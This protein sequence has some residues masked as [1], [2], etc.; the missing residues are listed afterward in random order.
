MT[1]TEIKRLQVKQVINH[2]TQEWDLINIERDA[3]YLLFE[4]N[5]NGYAFEGSIDTR[6]YNVFLADSMTL[7]GNGWSEDRLLKV[8]MAKGLE[9]EL[10]RAVQFASVVTEI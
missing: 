1:K 6:G 10:Q 5:Y 2:L 4:L 8:E 9:D 7:L 3:Q